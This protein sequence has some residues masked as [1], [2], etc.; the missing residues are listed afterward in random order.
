MAQF[1]VF[2]P[3][4]FAISRE[5]TYPTFEVAKQK[6]K[7]WVKRYEFQGH[8]S[9]VKYGRIPLDE[10]EYECTIVEVTRF[11]DLNHINRFESLIKR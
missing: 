7:E 10:L 8:Y 2:S 4:G 5:E 1:E 6:L 3:D 11:K 9:S